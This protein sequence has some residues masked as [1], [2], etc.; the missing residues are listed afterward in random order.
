M[1]FLLLSLGSCA[2]IKRIYKKRP[3]ILRT[4]GDP[5]DECDVCSAVTRHVEWAFETNSYSINEIYDHTIN[6][7]ALY[8]ARWQPFAI[9]I[10]KSNWVRMIKNLYNK[11]PL[12]NLCVEKKYCSK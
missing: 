12:Y 6:E 11:V 1:F 10:L 8:P 2:K 3:A 4:N 5:F 9:D 7:I